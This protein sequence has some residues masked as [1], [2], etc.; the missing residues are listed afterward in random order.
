MLHWWIIWFILGGWGSGLGRDL[1][2]Y[3]PRWCWKCAI[4][5]GGLGAIIINMVVADSIRDGGIVA[6]ALVSLAAG[7]TISRLVGGIL[8]M[9]RDQKG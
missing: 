5:V 6:T 3:W 4:I 8:G 1:D 9:G 2:D 7:Y